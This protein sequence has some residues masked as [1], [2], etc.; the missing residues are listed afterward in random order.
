MDL[1][2]ATKEATYLISILQEIG[3][4]HQKCFAIYNDNQGAHKLAKNLTFH[5]RSK[6]IDVRHH[7][8]RESLKQGKI[9][10]Y[11]IP[12]DDMMADVF[13]KPLT[14]PKHQKCLKLFGMCF[15]N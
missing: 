13:T 9:S 10:V 3:L 6:H 5:S 7:F 11:Y 14:G 12:T 1:S 4:D 8:I 15:L 2:E